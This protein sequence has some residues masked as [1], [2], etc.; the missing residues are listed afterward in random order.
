M[1][2]Q[3]LINSRNGELY[4]RSRVY[5]TGNWDKWTPWKKISFTN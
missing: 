5:N 4:T 2:S 1:A 3:I